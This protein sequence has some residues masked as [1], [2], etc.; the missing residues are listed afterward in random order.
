[1]DKPFFDA[2]Q[3]H[4]C[5]EALKVRGTLLSVALRSGLILSGQK[6]SGEPGR[7]LTLTSDGDEV[8]VDTLEIV[9]FW[10][11]PD[12]DF[13]AFPTHV[14]DEG[15]ME[16]FVALRVAAETSTDPTVVSA[17]RALDVEDERLRS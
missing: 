9:G 4:R 6:I 11:S 7:Q 12:P 3:H 14:E 16:A 15:W 2:S 1:M 5:V 13:L 10:T 17:N 8:A